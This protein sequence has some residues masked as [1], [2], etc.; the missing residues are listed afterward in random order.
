MEPGG[1]AAKTDN[2]IAL[3]LVDFSTNYTGC[4]PIRG[5]NY[6]YVMVKE[7]IQF[8]HVLGHSGCTYLC[9]NEPAIKEVQKR[10]VRANKSMGPA[11]HDK[12][13]AAYTHGNTLCEK[14]VSRAAGLA[15]TLMH[16]VQEKLSMKLNT[17][18]GLWSWAL[19]HASWLLNRFAVVNGNIPLEFVSQNDYQGRT[20]EFAEPAFAYTHAALR[21][22]PKWQRVIG[23]GKTESQ[24]TCV[25][26]TGA[27]V[28]LTR[29][30]RKVSTNWKCHLG[31]YFHFNAP[32]RRCKT[33]FGGRSVP[34][35]KSC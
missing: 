9:D 22:N 24:D 8:T 15:G 21:E 23:L 11:T 30:V 25:V 4:M 31:F 19:R 35:K 29:S 12:T 26:F 6:F 14:T 20:T 2:V 28:I 3:I 13:L 18:H 16:H 34:T 32:T 1:N 5:R 33:S 27:A 10:A 17:N 7:I